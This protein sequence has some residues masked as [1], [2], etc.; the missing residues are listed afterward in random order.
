MSPSSPAAVP[1]V[2]PFCPSREAAGTVLPREVVVNPVRG[3]SALRSRLT[4]YGPDPAAWDQEG[5][6]SP[7]QTPNL[8]D[9]ALGE[10]QRR[11]LTSPRVSA[12]HPGLENARAQG[13]REGEGHAPRPGCEAPRGKFPA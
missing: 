4:R 7:S 6:P 13:D 5:G 8:P 10:G 11:A 9:Q 12:G 3:C 1:G 2:P